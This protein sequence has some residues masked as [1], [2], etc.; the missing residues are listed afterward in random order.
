MKKVLALVLAFV[1]VAGLATV[2]MADDNDVTDAA[3]IQAIATYKDG[4]FTEVAAGHNYVPGDTYYMPIYDNGALVAKGNLDNFK[5]SVTVNEGKKL[6]D[7]A[8]LVTVETAAGEFGAATKGK[9][10]FVKIVTEDNMDLDAQTL[11]L[12]LKM[13]ASKPDGNTQATAA[14]FVAEFEYPETT[15]TELF[16]WIGEKVLFEDYTED[17]WQEIEMFFGEND[18]IS[19]ASK[20]YKQ[21]D[22]YIG[23]TDDVQEKYEELYGDEAALDY[24]WF[25]QPKAFKQAGT[26]TI[27][28]DMVDGE[29]APYLYEEKDGKLVQIK[30]AYDEDEEAFILKNVKTL[31]KYVISDIE[32]EVKDSVDGDETE[33]NPAT[34]ANDVVAIAAGLAVVSLVA[35]GAVSLKK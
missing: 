10:Y 22:L 20:M 32:L 31:G 29:N 5:L 7:S 9:Y 18:D 1:M 2:A 27:A 14:T 17:E 3:V 24:V 13:A 16:P 4:H 8:S 30:N 23:F 19:F 33:E 15:P 6:L 35:A 21:P 28:A 12:E 25:T 26:L 11:D 34:G